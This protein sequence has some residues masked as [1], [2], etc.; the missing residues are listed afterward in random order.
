MNSFLEQACPKYC[1]HICCLFAI[2]LTGYPVIAE[3][4]SSTE[5]VSEP[6]RGKC[7]DRRPIGIQSLCAILLQN[8]MAS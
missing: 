5:W 7:W 3:S 8:P 6:E 2:N 1:M 4:E